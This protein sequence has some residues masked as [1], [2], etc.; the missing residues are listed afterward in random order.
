MIKLT[1][2]KVRKCVEKELSKVKSQKLINLFLNEALKYGYEFDISTNTVNNVNTDTTTIESNNNIKE[3]SR[4]YEQNI[5][6]INGVARD[7]LVEISQTIDVEIFKRAIEIAT[8]KG[9]CNKGYINGIINQ[10]NS[11][12]IKTINDLKAFETNIKTKGENKHYEDESI[13]QKPTDKQLEQ[14]RRLLDEI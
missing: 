12:N 3:Y 10:W 7:W 9:K 8:D 5:G 6:L 13:Y 14:A 11:N 1:S 2:V 4:L